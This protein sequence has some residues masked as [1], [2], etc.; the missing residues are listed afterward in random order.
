M[1]WSSFLE[2]VDQ[3]TDLL[4][5][6]FTDRDMK[7]QES[8]IAKAAE[9]IDIETLYSLD[10]HSLSFIESFR[11]D[12]KSS[13]HEEFDSLLK[14]HLFKISIWRN[15]MVCFLHIQIFALF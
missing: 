9:I 6:M 5:E 11:Q 7:C 10:A 13:P 2:Q 1:T 15:N 8:L 12:S 3:Y 14:F 4:I